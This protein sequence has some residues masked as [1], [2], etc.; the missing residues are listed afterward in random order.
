MSYEFRKRGP[1]LK[2]KFNKRE[3]IRNKKLDLKSKKIKQKDMVDR[4][5]LKSE[6][7]QKTK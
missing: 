2:H 1:K 5:N 3:K 4:Q 6:E 7:L